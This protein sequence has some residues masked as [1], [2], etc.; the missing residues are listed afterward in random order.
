M[1]ELQ[2]DFTERTAEIDALFRDLNKA[3][4]AKAGR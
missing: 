2:S 4:R 3:M 1:S